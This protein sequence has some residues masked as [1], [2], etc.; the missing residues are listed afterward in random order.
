MK[1]CEQKKRKRKQTG[2][3]ISLWYLGV[4]R[5]GKGKGSKQRGTARE[6]EER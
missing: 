3:E 5:E 2:T 6:E 1:K 4:K